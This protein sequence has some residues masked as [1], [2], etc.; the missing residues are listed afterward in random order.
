MKLPLLLVTGLFLLSSCKPS[1]P[2]KITATD[3]GKPGPGAQTIKGGDVTFTLAADGKPLTYTRGNSTNLLSP[4]NP[5]PGFYMTTG[6]GPEE[7]TIPFISAESKHDKLILTA[8]DKTR[9]T[10][11]VNAGQNY[12]SFRLEKLENVPK[13]SEP[14]L[15]FRLD[16]NNVFPEF[17][18][19][20]Y[21]CPTSSRWASIRCF[22]TATWPYLWRRC[23][24][25]PL[26][27][28]AFFV[29]QGEDDHN[30]TMLRIWTGKKCHIRKSRENGPT[31]ARK[32]GCR[33][34]KRPLKM[35]TS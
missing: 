4:R 21:M 10:L 11:A 26:G 12:F 33:S 25:D 20:D 27:G 34:G 24:R 9:A 6:S 7:K 19:F 2:S 13:D 3:T 29:P 18:S 32:P 5:S 30:E 1:Q 35:E 16:F 22:G 14:V 23:D 15:N 17:V 28:F 31:S 8:A